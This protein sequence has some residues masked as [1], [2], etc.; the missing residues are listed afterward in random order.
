[1]STQYTLWVHG[2]GV[3]VQDP[4]PLTNISRFGSG[5][6]IV[7]HQFS[8]AWFHFPIPTP[9]VIADA[10]VRIIQ[11]HLDFGSKDHWVS[12]VYVFHGH[13]QVATHT[14]LKL[15]GGRVVH[16]FPVQQQLEVE[17][18]ICVSVRVST[19]DMAPDPPPHY[20]KFLAA[21]ATFEAV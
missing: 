18:G 17:K 7:M 19:D 21:G 12:R 4:S 8:N 2:S 10:H 3:Q 13:Y 5:C 20:I 1:M 15:Q 16:A 6:E 14:N 11:V 9:S